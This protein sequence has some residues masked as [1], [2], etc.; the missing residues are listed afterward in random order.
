MRKKVVSINGVWAG[1]SPNQAI[2]VD[3]DL[4][5]QEGEFVVLIG[6]NGSGKS[7]LLKTIL[8]LVPVGRGQIEVLGK[9][10]KAI[11]SARERLGYL[12]QNSLVDPKFPTT[13]LEAVLMGSYSKLGFIHRP[14]QKEWAEAEQRL[15]E[16]GLSHLSS[17]P[18]GTLSGGQRQRVLL[19]RALMGSPE[20]ILLD[21]PTTALDV[22]AQHDLIQLI[23]D[24]NRDKGLTVIMVTHDVNLVLAYADKIGYLKRRMYAF[25]SP[26][27]VLQSEILSKVYGTEVLVLEH[28]GS[29]RVV[30]GD[31]HV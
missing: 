6:P 9:K 17:S 24:L 13:A 5:V 4:T 3:I 2:L 1:Y 30:V 11:S 25:G 12:P 18:F 15:A 28:E 19:A 26:E 23:S 21:E 27:E 7:T 8:G 10:D 14:G 16:V 29:K 20:I 22:S 31:H